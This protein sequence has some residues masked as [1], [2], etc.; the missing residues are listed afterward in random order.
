MR[1]RPGSDRILGRFTTTFAIS[2]YHYKL[3]VRY[4]IMW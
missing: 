2:T 3:L 1:D 4:H